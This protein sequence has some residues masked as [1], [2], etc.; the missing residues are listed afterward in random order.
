MNPYKAPKSRPIE[1]KIPK[2]IKKWIEARKKGKIRYILITG[3][4]FWGMAMF[5]V[6]TFLLNNQ[7]NSI[8]TI[9]I[10]FI[11]WMIVGYFFGYIIWT[12]MERKY[13][14]YLSTKND[15]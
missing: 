9:V 7:P 2:D 4:G 12:M 5:F 6:N 11:V 14:K 8:T 10:S 15:R 13:E 1:T 3:M